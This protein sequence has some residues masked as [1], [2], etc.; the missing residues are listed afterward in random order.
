MKIAVYGVARDEE[1][2]V[3]EWFESS[4]DADF[5]LI[6]DTGSKDN[7]VSIAKDLGVSVHEAFFSPWDESMAKNVAM[8]LLPKDIDLC[9]LLDL[10][11]RI[12]TENWKNILIDNLYNKNYN[13]IQ[14]ELIDQ[15]DFV[16]DNLN[17]I[18]IQNI[19]SRKNCFWYKYRPRLNV[20]LES[21]SY[22]I[23]YVPISFRNVIGNEERFIDRESVYLNSWENEY[24]K[25]KDLLSFDQNLFLMEYLFD[26]IAHQA[27]VLF[28][29]N[30]INEFLKK[31]NEYFE[32]KQKYFN[33][34][35]E[36]NNLRFEHFETR[37]IF[38]NSLLYPKH[39][40]KYLNFINQDS[41]YYLNSIVKLDIINFWKNGIISDNIKN[42]SSFEKIY[43]YSDSKTGRH[44][45]EL[46]KKAYKYFSGKEY[47]NEEK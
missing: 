14:H 27:Y 31:Q 11:Q 45:I 38:I 12:H 39:A 9:I 16:N 40:E 15:I 37:F 30:K 20:I 21:E 36:V 19:H 1:N 41:P 29:T 4:K 43:A 17:R 13:I 34:T 47:T 18:K 3:K 28:E 26:I 25:I 23:F 10:D 35:G 7:T 5:H 6:L 32:L 44:S 24:K 33:L 8:S 22:P 42:M 46:A 2:N